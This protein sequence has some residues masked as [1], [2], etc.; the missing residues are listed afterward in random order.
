MKSQVL[1][2]VWCNISGEAAGAK[3]EIDRS[4]EWNSLLLAGNKEI[5]WL[6]GKQ[7]ETVESIDRSKNKLLTGS[8]TRR[9]VMLKY[10]RELYKT[11]FSVNTF[12][13]SFQLIILI[14]QIGCLKHLSPRPFPGVHEP[15]QIQNGEKLYAV[16]GE[17]FSETFAEFI[18]T[19]GLRK[20][21][22]SS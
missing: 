3:S 14:L 1:P 6:K 16:F 9:D 18:V 13:H 21:Y 8:R 10:K 4:W 7:K 19:V 20:V 11:G 22:E 12:Q 17:S 15:Y 5:F 2:T